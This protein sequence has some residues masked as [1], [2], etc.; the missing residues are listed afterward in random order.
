MI[1]YT[2]TISDQEQKILEHDLLDIKDWIN[3]SIEGKINN[4]LK[5]LANQER[6][7][8]VSEGALTAPARLVDLA[9]SAFSRPDYLNRKDRDARE[10][11]EISGRRH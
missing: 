9:N 11:I 8:L 4:V 1:V 6:E 10:V 2:R 5:R 7:K 3:K